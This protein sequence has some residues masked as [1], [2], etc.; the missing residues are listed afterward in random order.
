MTGLV[1]ARATHPEILP[2]NLTAS[3]YIRAC[4]LALEN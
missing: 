1:S 2:S 3:A 4:I